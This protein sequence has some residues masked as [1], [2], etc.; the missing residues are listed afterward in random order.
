M[1]RQRTSGFTLV[2]MLVVIAIIGILAALLIPAVQAARESARG[3]ECTN[4]QRQIGLAIT[5]FTAAKRHVPP[6]RT[7]H[8]Y[9]DT[10]PPPIS[11]VPMIFPY[12]GNPDLWKVVRDGNV[13]AE[14]V[15]I[16]MC[17]SDPP[18]DD[19]EAAPNSYAVNG[20]RENSTSA[21]PNDWTANGLC[22]DRVARAT[23]KPNDLGSIEDGVATT[24]MLSENVNL[25]QWTDAAQEFQSAILWAKA[26]AQQAGFNKD[27]DVPIDFE[28]ARPSSRHPSIFIA[29]FCDGHV[30]TVSEEINYEVYCKLMSSDG[31][32]ARDPGAPVTA[33]PDPAFQ[34]QPV[35]EADIP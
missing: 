23:R 20:G 18:Y 33:A 16:F 1:S 26:Q 19:S 22:D 21:D 6:T 17:P 14:R 25:G 30:R 4:N 7:N 13:P 3:A 27:V 31:R 24:L 35:S 9:D 8:P 15:S 29:T 34:G 28:H 12:S 11:W 32:R 5:Q 10:S 2:E